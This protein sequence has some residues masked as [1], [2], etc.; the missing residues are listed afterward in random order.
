MET[1]ISHKFLQLDFDEEIDCLLSVWQTS[2][3]MRDSDYQRL[4]LKYYE[5]VKKL[6]P[7][8]LLINAVHAKYAIS[9]EMQNWI[10]NLVFPLYEELEVE[11][12][13]I[14]MS[15]HFIAQLSFEETAEDIDVRGMEVRYFVGHDKAH[16][17]LKEGE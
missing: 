2:S 16:T 5:A 9:V 12:M 15:E 1:I 14:V 8:N 6:K 3:D 10:N 17:W 13:A 4:F 11:K 7:K